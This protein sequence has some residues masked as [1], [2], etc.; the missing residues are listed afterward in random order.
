M[1]RWCVQMYNYYGSKEREFVKKIYNITGIIPTEVEV[2]RLAFRHISILSSDQS[3]AEEC[4][5][6]LE[7]LGDAILGAVV[8]EFLFQKYPHK[9]EGYLTEMRSKIVG[10]NALNAVGL[11]I[12]LD[13]IIETNNKTPYLNRTINGNTFEALVG[14]IYLD[15][16]YLKTR[17]FLRT[18]F[19]RNH[20]DLHELEE[21]NLNFKSRLLEYLQKNQLPPASFILV[22]ERLN[23]NLKEFTVDCTLMG[24]CLGTGKDI[25]K[26]NAEQK[27][28][29]QAFNLLLELDRTGKNHLMVHAR[30]KTEDNSL[31]V[32][33]EI[34]E[35]NNPD[36]E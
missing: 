19:I 1:L 31:K 18:R 21:Q 17:K 26:K 13:Q 20:F 29:E 34:S 23:G 8:G 16:G 33:Q 15:V 22:S 4:N 32:H 35:V 10:R 25:K 24:E 28:A 7:F 6:R 11:K 27:A 2:Y 9:S 30:K 36:N 5:E 12:G 14:A 3:V